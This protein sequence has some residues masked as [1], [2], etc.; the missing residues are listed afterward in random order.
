MNLFGAVDEFRLEVRP[1]IDQPNFIRPTDL[2]L[3]SRGVDGFPSL[4]LVCDGI[5]AVAHAVYSYRLLLD[6]CHP[7]AHN[8]LMAYNSMFCFSEI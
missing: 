3:V 4:L 1:A 8:T 6:L 5:P 2:H 7:F